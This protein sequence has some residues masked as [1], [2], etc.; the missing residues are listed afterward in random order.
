MGCDRP[1]SVGAFAFA[2]RDFDISV[3]TDGRVPSSSFSTKPDEHRQKDQQDAD[4]GTCGD[5]SDC[6][7]AQPTKRMLGQI[8][9]ASKLYPHGDEGGTGVGSSRA[10]Q[11]TDGPF[12]SSSRS[13]MTGK[14]THDR[15]RRNKSV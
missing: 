9:A 11:T 4:D 3:E 12:S 15:E 1:S 7:Y 2:I 13:R 10:L 6:A 8:P 14:G 5:S